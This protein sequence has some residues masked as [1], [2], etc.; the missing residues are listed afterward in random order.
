MMPEK[1]EYL[2]QLLV[3]ARQDEQHRP[4][5]EGNDP[6]RGSPVP[7]VNPSHPSKRRRVLGHREAEPRRADDRRREAPEDRDQNRSRQQ[8]ARRRAE[9]RGRG[10]LADPGGRAELRQ[11]QS[12]EVD[13]VHE[14]IDHTNQRGPANH[15]EREIALWPLDLTGGERR[16]VPAVEVAQDRHD[17]EPHGREQVARRER[18]G[19]IR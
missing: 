9:Q 16:L 18:R 2:K 14:Q 15:P 12:L 10:L 5:T 4:D 7:R 13:Q 19:P 1:S 6:G 8:P 3:A 17:R 11:W